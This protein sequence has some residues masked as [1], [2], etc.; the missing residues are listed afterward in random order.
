MCSMGKLSP[1][2]SEF[3]ST[4]AAEVYERWFR[5]K[6]EASLAD[7]R[8]NVPHAAVMAELDDIIDGVERRSGRASPD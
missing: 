6:V 5:A 1:I 4:E 8:P 3:D 2:E 7:P